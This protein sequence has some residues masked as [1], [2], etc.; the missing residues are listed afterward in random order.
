MALI[1]LRLLFEALHLSEEIRYAKIFKNPEVIGTTL[2]VQSKPNSNVNKQKTI[3]PFRPLTIHMIDPC[4][5]V[6]VLQMEQIIPFV[7]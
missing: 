4:V 6:T 3:Y 7:N 5:L 2:C 1:R